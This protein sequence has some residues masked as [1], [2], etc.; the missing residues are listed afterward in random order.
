[1]R[2]S[3][4]VARLATGLSL[5]CLLAQGVSGYVDGSGLSNYSFP[6]DFIFGVATAAFQIE[7]AWNTGNK[8]ESM[9]DTYLHKHPNFTVDGSNGDV[10]TDSYHKYKTDIN[11]VKSL[12]LK[13]YRMS[14]SWPRILPQGTDNVINKDGVRY[15]RTVFKEL[16]KENIIP[17]VT[18]FH[19]DLPTALMD[20]GGWSNP[21][22]IDYFE[23]YAKVAF[24]LFGDVIK[25]W[26]TMNE[27]HQHCSNGYGGDN[28]VPAMMS[29]GV[30][31]YLCTHYM[32]LAH[33]RAY[34]LYDKSFRPQQKGKIGITLDAFY[35]EPKDPR[36]QSDIDAAERYLQMHLGIFAHPIYSSEG[37]YPPLVR[38]RINNISLS[39]GFTRSRLPYFTNSEIE[40]LRG[41]SDFF[42]L[43]HYTTYLM[44]DMPMLKGWRVPSWDH[45][46]GVLLEQNPLWPKPG[47]DWLAVYPLGFR[48]VLNWITRNYG[49]RIP[50][51]V[52]ENGVSDFGGLNDY[53][54]V[55]YYNNYLYQMLLAMYEDG[56]NIQGYFAWTLMDDFEWKDGY[57]VKFGL[58]HVDFNS[59]E[60]TR[61][62]KLSAF[63][64][65]EIV[66]RRRINFKYIEQIPKSHIN[67]L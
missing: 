60:K 35:A 36:K 43:N 29:G 6:E 66:R 15:Y 27:P 18:L 50:I 4:G 25:H 42:G 9:W 67:I 16:L 20:L 28:F 38:E 47:A 65:A 7:G 19:W 2:S 1:M 54:R 31:E 45:D 3:R 26:S 40:L 5:W 49:T 46:T 37:D 32:L 44:S 63:N 10:A 22:M 53:A 17:V 51:I 21:K 23:D 11:C 24:T 13:Y 55:S 59:T 56:C 33:S 57:T 48:K 8:G 30:G 41:S 52:T 14:I 64:Y 58:F 39:Q 34:H 62:P 61:V 12:G